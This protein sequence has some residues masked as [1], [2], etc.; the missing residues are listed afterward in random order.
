MLSACRTTKSDPDY[1]PECVEDAGPDVSGCVSNAVCLDAGA[2]FCE[3]DAGI[4]TGCMRDTDCTHISGKNMC[5]AGACVQCTP[6]DES[7]CDGK[8]CDPE[9]NSCTE[10]TVASIDTCEPCVSDTE[11]VADHKCVPLDYDGSFHGNYCMKVLSATCERPYLVVL[12]KKSVLAGEDEAAEQFCGIN[13]SL[14]SC[15]A[16]LAFISPCTTDG[17]CQVG[18]NETPISGALCRTVNGS[19]SKCT[20]KCSAPAQCQDTFGCTNS[21]NGVDYC[22]GT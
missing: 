14:S 4:C 22:G 11:C 18:G 9:N 12:N 16:V 3:V 7:A 15:E 20:Y 13:E 2:S 19:P 1:C 17:S 6:E 21:G 5:S 10:T 8:S